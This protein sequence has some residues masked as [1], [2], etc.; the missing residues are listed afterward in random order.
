MDILR[1]ITK[2]QRWRDQHN[3]S[4]GNARVVLTILP[5]SHFVSSIFSVITQLLKSLVC[6]CLGNTSSNPHNNIDFKNHGTSGL[7]YMMSN[8]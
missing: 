2:C 4:M 7:T 1:L 3:T 8:S 5:L 6:I